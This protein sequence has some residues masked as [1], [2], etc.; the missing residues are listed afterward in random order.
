MLVKD[1]MGT[2]VRRVDDSSVLR[3]CSSVQVSAL[4]RETAAMI[5]SDP[6]LSSLVG[7]DQVIR[8]V[9][10]LFARLDQLDRTQPLSANGSPSISRAD[11]MMRAIRAQS[12][13]V[14]ASCASLAPTRTRQGI[15]GAQPAEAKLAAMSNADLLTLAEGPNGPATLA[16][17]KK[18]LSQ[19][20]MTP[21]KQK[22]LDRINAAT[23]TPGPGLV[24]QG[25]AADTRAYLH[26]TREA[27]LESPSFAKMMNQISNDA[28]HPVRLVLERNT[29]T[30]L[31]SFPKQTLDLSDLEKLPARPETDRPEQITRGQ[32]LAHMMREQ[33]HKAFQGPTKDI[34]P[35]HRAAI[36]AENAYRKDIG[37]KSMRLPP[38]NDETRAIDDH[39][40]MI[41]IHFDDQHHEALIFDAN[42]NLNGSGSYSDAKP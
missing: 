23:F 16:A 28:Q 21:A 4:P 9:P 30:A 32:V 15:F 3:S 20:A 39:G 7:K 12:N 18:E 8:D 38:P 5:N 40:I 13:G 34:A 35:A 19:G 42:A 37:Q 24:V 22:Q 14:D 36:E 2:G 41:T 33:Q 29:G 11:T 25:N 17:Y 31:D 6:Q 10:A 1:A 27:M 26:M